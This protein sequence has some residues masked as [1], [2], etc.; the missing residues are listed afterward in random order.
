MWKTLLVVYLTFIYTAK[1]ANGKKDK[2]ELDIPLKRSKRWKIGTYQIQENVKE[3]QKI[4]G[5]S[6]SR[7]SAENF[8]GGT[9]KTRPKNSTIKPSSTLLVSCMKMQEG[10]DP[11]PALAAD[12]HGVIVIL[13][14]IS[15]TAVVVIVVRASAS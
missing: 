12:A 3:E 13:Y 1:Y 9:E 8:Q 4:T 2:K 14:F 7:A 11:P 15:L 10:H 5:V 6:Y